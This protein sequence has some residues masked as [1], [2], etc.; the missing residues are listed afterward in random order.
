MKFELKVERHYPHTVA[1]VWDGLTT[2]EGISDWLMETSN[3]RPEAGHRFEMSCLD[4]AGHLDVYRSEVLELD[5]PHRMV[6]SWVLAGEED[7]GTSEVEFRLVPTDTGTTVT[8]IHRGDLDQAAIDRFKSGWQPKLDQLAE[9][10]IRHNQARQ[11]RN[12]APIRD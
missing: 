9:T 7:T 3:F 11:A 10:L 12:D 5:P 6:W 8:L 4:D 1:E 2:N